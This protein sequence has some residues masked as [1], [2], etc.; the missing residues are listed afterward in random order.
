MGRHKVDVRMIRV[1]GLGR[2]APPEQVIA[3][4]EGDR[5]GRFQVLHTPGHTPGSSSFWDGGPQPRSGAVSVRGQPGPHALGIPDLCPW[6]TLDHALQKR[7]IARYRAA[8]S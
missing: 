4:R 6:W 8:S 2:T 5:V 1:V 3:L 7:S